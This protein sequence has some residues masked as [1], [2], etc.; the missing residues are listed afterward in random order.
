MPE[1]TPLSEVSSPQQQPTP[2]AA[3]G[4][5]VEHVTWSSNSGSDSVT[6]PIRHH[7]YYSTSSDSSLSDSLQDSGVP[8]TVVETIQVQNSPEKD[9]AAGPSGV[10][11]VIVDMEVDDVEAALARLNQFMNRH[12]T[13]LD[14]DHSQI[15]SD[16]LGP[17]AAKIKKLNDLIRT[18][19][20]NH[21][22]P[23]ALQED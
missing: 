19:A 6:S 7:A 1:Y 4:E 22:L 2:H 21:D 11:D 5:F 14:S 17:E 13:T 9:N 10:K 16:K 18:H 20:F 12:A 8:Q 23:H 15:H 3:T